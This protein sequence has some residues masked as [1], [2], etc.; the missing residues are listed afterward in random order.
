MFRSYWKKT[1]NTCVENIQEEESEYNTGLGELQWY[2]MKFEVY[3][4]KELYIQMAPSRRTRGRVSG[5]YTSVISGRSRF[6]WWNES[7]AFEQGKF[8]LNLQSRLVVIWMGVWPLSPASHPAVDVRVPAVP[9]V[10]CGASWVQIRTTPAYPLIYDH[11]HITTARSSCKHFYPSHSAHCLAMD[12]HQVA[13]IL[14]IVFDLKEV[15]LL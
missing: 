4:E 14:T 7:G 6:L 1:N 12:I 15:V 2:F 11:Y 5:S 13:L 9:S 3:Q 10:N 8:Q